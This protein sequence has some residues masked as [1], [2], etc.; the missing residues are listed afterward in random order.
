[1]SAFAGLEFYRFFSGLR[2]RSD[3]V[4]DCGKRSDGAFCRE[5]SARLT[6]VLNRFSF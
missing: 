6:K 4:E 1:M 3:I 2:A 5:I